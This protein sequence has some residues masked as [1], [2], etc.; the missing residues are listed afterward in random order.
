MAEP[1]LKLCDRSMAVLELIAAGNSYEQ[2]LAIRPEL[3]YLDIF[4][5]AEEAFTMAL[6]LQPERTCTLAEKRER[7]ARS[8]EKWSDDE[9]RTLRELVQSSA[10]AAQIAGRLQ[11]NRGAIRSRI[12]KLNLVNELIPKEQERFRRIVERCG[13]DSDAE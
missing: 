3:T 7:H 8:Y 4:H 13:D 5:A 6:G 11:R 1:H 12:I 9:D 10:T 2:I